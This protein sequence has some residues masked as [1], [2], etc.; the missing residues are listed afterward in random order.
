[1][2][3]WAHSTKQL[4]QNLQSLHKD[5]K[6]CVIRHQGDVNPHQRINVGQKISQPIHQALHLL[7][8]KIISTNMT[9]YFIRTITHKEILPITRRADR[10]WSTHHDTSNL[11]MPMNR[12]CFRRIGLDQ[13]RDL[14]HCSAVRMSST[15]HMDLLSILLDIGTS[16][17][18]HHSILRSILI[19]L[20]EPPTL[21]EEIT[22]MS[23]TN[24][25]PTTSSTTFTDTMLMVGRSIILSLP[26]NP[27]TLLI[28][29]SHIR[30]HLILH[31]NLFTKHSLALKV[32]LHLKP[33][34]NNISCNSNQKRRNS[35]KK[36][37]IS[38]GSAMSS[39]SKTTRF[40]KTC[41]PLHP[42]KTTRS[43]KWQSWTE[44]ASSCPNK[45]RSSQ[46]RIGTFNPHWK[47]HARSS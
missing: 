10:Q 37:K 14:H 43:K 24:H 47:Q 34:I 46:M 41:N 22:E 36:W 32:M 17:F 1:M 27:C 16:R 31:S 8:S 4:T 23:H 2:I 38:N 40:H 29:I 5:D 39:F 21:L 42:N 12:P 44:N 3:L 19:D 25:Q 28:M 35:I 15:T 26:Y 45:T 33:N 18:C 9:L 13:Q 30:S 6:N 11:N 7:T 20:M